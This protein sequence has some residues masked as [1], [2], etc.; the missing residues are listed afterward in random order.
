MHA[1]ADTA[2]LIGWRAAGGS[3]FGLAWLRSGAATDKRSRVDDRG[4]VRTESRTRKGRTVRR[5]PQPPACLYDATTSD[6]AAARAASQPPPRQPKA[7][8][9]NALAPNSAPR[10]LPIFDYHDAHLKM[11][12]LSLPSYFSRHNSTAATL[13]FLPP[14]LCRYCTPPPPP[15]CIVHAATPLTTRTLSLAPTV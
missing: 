4:G 5:T 9:Y 10:S 14:A 13:A 11:D 2:M 6:D 3:L 8:V 12:M 15:L 7:A 1:C